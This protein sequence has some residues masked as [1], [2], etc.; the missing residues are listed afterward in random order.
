MVK[1]FG[2]EG[3]GREEQKVGREGGEKGREE[4]GGYGGGGKGG[5]R[6]TDRNWGGGK[7]RGYMW[8]CEGRDR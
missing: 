3:S 5:R 2:E 4:Q 1:E 8:G 7:V 6:E